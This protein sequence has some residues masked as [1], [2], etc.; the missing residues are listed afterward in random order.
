ME[1]EQT[2]KK[3]SQRFDPNNFEKLFNEADF[4]KNGKIEKEEMALF[5]KKSFAEPKQEKLTIS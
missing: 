4:N 2:D 5:I 3:K 1:H